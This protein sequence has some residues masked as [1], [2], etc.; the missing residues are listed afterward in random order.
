MRLTGK[1]ADEG[2]SGESDLI[3]TIGCQM[4]QTRCV[5][6]FLSTSSSIHIVLFNCKDAGE[7]KGIILVFSSFSFSLV[8]K[9]DVFSRASEKS[10]ILCIDCMHIHFVC[11]Y[12]YCTYADTRTHILQSMHTDVRINIYVQTHMTGSTHHFF[13]YQTTWLCKERQNFW[14]SQHSKHCDPELYA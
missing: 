6:I 5:R 9:K 11:K 13:T 4:V 12:I 14:L 7:K 10:D 2:G 3:Y 8:K 1:Q